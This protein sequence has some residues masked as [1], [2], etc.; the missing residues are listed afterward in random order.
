MSRDKGK[1][2]A[3]IKG[4]EGLYQVSDKGE[5]ISLPRYNTKGGVLKQYVSPHNGYCY[6]SLS[7]GKSRTS[8]RVHCLVMAAFNPKPKAGLE[9]DHKDRNKE[10]NALDNLEWV[11]HT[12]NIRRRG[13]IK[14][15][16]VPVIDL[17]TKEVFESEILA[18]ESLG[19]KKS[20]AIHRVCTGQRSHYKGHRFAFYK[21]GQND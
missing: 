2:Y 21:G 18:A 15:H 1:R 12:E 6:V 17:D 16:T 19:G 7:K 3:D 11:T 14:F 13:E 10:N 9:I 4:Y 20:S 8:K 5:V